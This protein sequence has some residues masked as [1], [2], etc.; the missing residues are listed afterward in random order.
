MTNHVHILAGPRREESLARGVGT[1]NL[2]YTQHINRKYARSGRLWQNRFFSTI[3]D[4]DAYLWAV[5]SYIERNP[6]R[7]GIVATSEDYRWSSSRAHVSGI[8]D[9]VLSENDCFERM[10]IGSYR[11]YVKREDDESSALIRKATSSGR[12]L[13]S[14]GFTR[15]MESMLD[16]K[17]LPNRAGRPRKMKENK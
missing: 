16:R 13:G 4:R 11:D 17:L 1:T 10:E 6:V 3:V 8:A 7:A 2:V 5:A 12:P 14:E 9:P 15:R